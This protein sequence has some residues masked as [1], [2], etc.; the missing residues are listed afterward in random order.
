MARYWVGGSGTWDGT[1][2]T[3]WSASSGGAGGASAPTSA[4]D[5]IFNS[6]SN[7]TAYTVTISGGATVCRSVTVAGPA[8]GNVTFS[9]TT[10]WSVYGSFTLPASGITWSY[11][12]TITFASTSTGN[13][14]TTNGISLTS[15]PIVFNGSGGGWTLGSAL[16]NTTVTFT[17]GTFS[18]GNY[19]CTGTVWT[20]SGTG[21]T[22]VSLGSSTITLAN[23]NGWSFGTTTGLTFNAGT[24]TINLSNT[25]ITFAFGG[26]TYNN[27]N[28]NS[29]INNSSIGITGSNTFAN[30]TIATPGGT[31]VRPVNFSANQTITGTFT[32]NGGSYTNRMLIQSNTLGTAFTIT[33]ATVSVSY[34]DFRDITG[35]GAGTWSGTSLGDCGGNSGITFTGAKTV[36]WNLAGSQN[37][38]ATGWA[39][40]SGGTPAAANFPLAQ[41]TAIVDQNSAITTLTM[42]YVWNVGTVN[43]SARTSAMTFTY[44]S[45]AIVYGDW[46]NG[47]GVTI[48]GSSPVPFNGRNKTQTI[49]SN[50]VQMFGITI[51]AI[52]GTVAIN[53]NFTT[54]ATT[55]TSTLTYG[56]L[57]L[58]NGGA[59]NY[60][61]STGLFSSSNSNTR[62]ITFGSGQITCTGSGTAFTTATKTNLTITVGTGTISMTS[63]S[64]KTFAGGGATFPTLNQGGS[65]ALTI[66]GANTFTNIT[67][68]VQPATI[69]FP[70]STTNTFTN[71][72]LS[73]TA[74][75]LITIN[76]ST[77][78]TRATV[79]KSSGT[80]SVNYLSIQDSAATGGASW[81]AGAN[82]T[83]V[84]NNTG[85]IFTAPPTGQNS[86]FF[87]FF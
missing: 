13:T 77:S 18:T 19:N 59:G 30:L 32:A 50:G 34:A 9:G 78:G 3:N 57:D 70:A 60:T 63:A 66:Q 40:S 21:T 58:T 44:T 56:T 52:G 72:S 14:I 85:W 10:A 64:A 5:V 33:A 2:T 62:A 4:D 55:L 28:F 6:A 23:T 36:Y 15:T 82:S 45:L 22:S 74:G 25:G 27:V 68:T 73:G 35:A 71:F 46:S 11:S 20:N 61:F 83:N 54:Y 87:A 69:T 76:S 48:G 43:M 7:A 65:G 86:N 31:G 12:G 51:N 67:N 47:T 81:Y 1:T 84:S 75:N 17:N 29:T 8:S 80:V 24:S 53:G 49:T 79:S 38:S 26:L 37:W 41:D 39:T 42:D 16:T